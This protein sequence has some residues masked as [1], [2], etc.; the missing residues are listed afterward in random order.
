METIS[1]ESGIE[2]AE[3][4]YLKAQIDYAI[5]K[6]E[7]FPDEWVI[8]LFSVW[9][10]KNRYLPPGI[11]D[12]DGMFD[13]DFA[14]HLNEI[15]DR[16]HPD[17]PCRR[18]SVIKSVQALVTTTV[19]E[20]AMGAWIE[21]QL[22]SIL[23]V[24][25]NKKIGEIRGSANI[26]TLIDYSNL[27]DSLQP[28]SNRSNKKNK[29]SALYKEFL[30]NMQ[31]L[32]TSYKAIGD[33][34]SNPF[35][36]LILDELDEAREI[37]DQGDPEA[38][39]DG[40]TFAAIDYKKLEISTTSSVGGSRIHKNVLAGDRRE[41]YIPCPI[42]GEHQMP[43]LKKRGDKYG[44]TFK[45]DYQKDTGEKILKP[46]T[47]KYI[48]K[49]C[50]KSFREHKKPWML[51]NGIWRA[52]AK[53]KDPLHHS[54][55]VPAFISP[56]FP[57][58][59][60]CQEFVNC[61]FGSDIPKFKGFYI[62][63]MAKPWSAT[64]K[65]LDWK[66]L[67]ARAENYV[68]GE[69]PE[70]KLEIIS[71]LPVYLGP[72]VLYGG[73]D[74]QGDR[75]ELLVVAFGYNGEKWII[76][77]QIF[78]GNT[79]VIDDYCYLSLSD[80]VY[81]HEYKFKDEIIFIGKVAMDAGWDP[82]KAAKRDKDFNTK[83][84]IVYEFVSQRRDKFV[85]VMGAPDDKAIGIIKESRINDM[86]TTL[87]KKYYVSVS[88]L[89]DS[90]MSILE[91]TE[92]FNTIHVPKYEI[93][94]GIKREIGDEFF[95]QILSERY[96]EDEK[97]PGVMIWKKIRARNEML[98][99]LIYSIAASAVDSIGTWSIKIWSGYYIDLMDDYEDDED[100]E[101]NIEDD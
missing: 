43:D 3:E 13:P 78:Y 14:P 99:M 17:D 32:V 55:R 101:E 37:K 59:R 62:N 2:T 16:L 96:Q 47:I 86:E 83:A 44:L 74:V 65:I 87:K 20:N 100:N 10:T 39:I 34:K 42:C 82:R 76:D 67:K 50:E 60:I 8:E 1:L 92:G 71:G 31:L 91:N 15:L 48:C 90:I 68:L 12:F 28:F 18:I 70:G 30:G 93:I 9:A 4:I 98:D 56:A 97:R 69:I 35:K 11:T 38:L 23:Y 53:A 79:A 19:A 81:E 52:T 80:Y 29:D 58:Q 49:F 26:D 88:L 57:W 75:L 73:V 46:E 84:H 95:E 33:L 89:K 72:M 85:A 22:G 21:N 36:L 51:I 66:I 7:D 61:G 63:V 94:E 54:Y 25:S 41:Y 45:T 77:K 27:S 6:I 64:T 24:T 5:K 40:R